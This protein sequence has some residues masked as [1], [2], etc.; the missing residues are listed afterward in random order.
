MLATPVAVY[1]Q[2]RAG[3]MMGTACRLP[4][5]HIGTALATANFGE[6]TF[7]KLFGKSGGGAGQ[8][9]ESSQEGSKEPRSV[10]SCRQ[11]S[12]VERPSAIFQTVSLRGWVNKGTKRGEGD[13]SGNVHGDRTGTIDRFGLCPS[14]DLRSRNALPLGARPG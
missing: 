2:N 5:T 7:Q 8:G 12:P 11:I 1:G 6:F 4:R 9:S 14:R 3:G 10:A 13:R